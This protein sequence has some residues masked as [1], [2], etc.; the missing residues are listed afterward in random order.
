LS[1]FGILGFAAGVLLLNLPET[2]NKV[3]PETVDQAE[4][5]GKPRICGWRGSKKN[6]DAVTVDSTDSARSLL[7][8]VDSDEETR[9]VWRLDALEKI[10]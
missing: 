6:Y 7:D 8:D 3:L 1:I 5:F 4:A 9:Q 10:K 2:W